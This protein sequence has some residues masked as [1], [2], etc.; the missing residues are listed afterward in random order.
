R[1]QVSPRPA[2]AAPP[3]HHPDAVP[4]G[5]LPLAFRSDAPGGQRPGRRLRA[6]RRS[7]PGARRRRLPALPCSGLRVA[8]HAV[9][10][11]VSTVRRPALDS[12]RSVTVDLRDG[13]PHRL[14]RATD[15]ASALSPHVLAPPARGA[16]TPLRRSRAVGDRRTDRAVL[17]SLA[18]APP[19]WAPAGATEPLMRRL[20]PLYIQTAIDNLLHP[21]VD[22]VNRVLTIPRSKHGGG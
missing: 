1:C 21:D 19:R 5:R 22:L 16:A 6:N 8:G 18:A 9:P 2:L 4:G 3:A 11:G 14:S 12:A 13:P 15:G 20:G 7:H 10:M 17:P